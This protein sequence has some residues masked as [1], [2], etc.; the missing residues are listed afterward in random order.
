M[1]DE[2]FK[3]VM[4]GGLNK[5]QMKECDQNG[6][7]ALPRTSSKDELRELYSASNVFFNPT[8]EEMFGLVNIEAQVANVQSFRLLSMR[9]P[10]FIK[11]DNS[12]LVESR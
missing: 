10:F 1:L 8:R 4:I 3:I 9:Q 6:I 11:F 7:M 5:E 12:I 2:R